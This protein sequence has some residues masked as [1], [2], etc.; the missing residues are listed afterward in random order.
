V[1][2]VLVFVAGI[3]ALSWEILWQVRLMLAVGVS[4]IATAITL[5]ATMA[6]MTLGALVA[7]R[8]LSKREID[9]PLFAYAAL[10][11]VIGLWG[12]LIVAPGA[13]LLSR[14]DVAAY[15]VS[16]ALAAPLQL[17]GLVVLLGPQTIAMG[18]TAP[19]F[20]RIAEKHGGTVASLYAANTAGGAAGV[21]LVSFGILPLV[22]VEVTGVAL[23]SIDLIV[24]LGAV[25][26]ASRAPV[27][28]RTTTTTTTNDDDTTTLPPRVALIVL[29]TG[30][31]AF[32][33][34]V[35]W[36]RA[37][38]SAF[39][40]TTQTF[41]IV[42]TSVLVPLAL[43]ARAAPWFAKRKNGIAIALL[44]AAVAIL[45]ATPLLERFDW[46]P[47]AFLGTYW[48]MSF[49]WLAASLATVGPAMFLLGTG[50]P[51]ALDEL[52]L[53][54]LIGRA[55]ALNTIGAVIGALAAA[56]FL[57]PT[58]GFSRTSW[59]L[60]AAMAAVAIATTSSRPT[61]LFGGGAVMVALLIAIV[62]ASGVGR[63]RVL[64]NIAGGARR[65]VAYREDPDATIAVV[66]SDT[67]DRTLV[68]DGFAASSDAANSHYMPW[69]G[70]L[71]MIRH[72]DPEVALVICFGTG[73][74]ANAVRK[75]GPRELDI[76]DVSPGV[77]ALANQFPANE[78]VLSDPRVHSI[79]M[80]GRAW[81][82]RTKRT[83]DVITLE[84]M[85]P[86]FA[87]VNALYS[88]EFYELAAQRLG[89]GG[90]IAQWLPFHSLT[91]HDARAIVAT[92]HAVFFDTWVWIDPASTTGIIV[93]GK[94]P[95]SGNPARWPGL[96]RPAEGRD[97]KPSQVLGSLALGPIEVERYIE[98]AEIITDDNQLLAYGFSRHANYYAIRTATAAHFLAIRKAHEADH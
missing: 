22:G 18:A 39:F 13:A 14:L 48:R 46:V 64:G 3:A 62:F 31:I 35:A 42:L 88:R 30:F 57:L 44:G 86:N 61:R 16:P 84:P 7:G 94:R 17:V 66:E 72:E 87:G 83:Y 49:V 71:P 11:G 97:M 90:V 19:V 34:E 36:F 6:G 23:A 15:A 9:R 68:I 27:I 55:Y 77:F 21:L 12:V 92:F 65:V 70:H 95:P 63:T 8:M 74:T 69:M 33:L 79:V 41:A 5:V 40:S 38:R 53:T 81:L 54:R 2:R 37:M 4:A 82:R 67:G 85:P 78:G 47:R 45:V 51:W 26:F 50:L 52:G 98:G 76:V 80:D 1:A 32:A 93:G 96:A 43:G 58:L 28:E 89:D 10:E 91:V 59:L 25:L 60:G 73:Q 20:G 56:W 29:M 24:A 75:E